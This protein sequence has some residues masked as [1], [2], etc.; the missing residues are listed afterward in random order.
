M[1]IVLIAALLFRSLLVAAQTELPVN[2][3]GQVLFEEIVPSDSTSAQQLYG[4]ALAW[5]AH[6]FKSPKD[7]IEVKDQPSALIVGKGNTQ[8]TWGGMSGTGYLSFTVEIAAKDNR[9]K[10]SF[11]DL[12]FQDKSFRYPPIDINRLVGVKNKTAEKTRQNVLKEMNTLIS[13]LKDAMNK[14]QDW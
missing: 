8:M 9:Y 13:G 11:S 1:K 10:Y 2:T 14:K 6:T 3:S 5:F 4:Y 12:K 7:V